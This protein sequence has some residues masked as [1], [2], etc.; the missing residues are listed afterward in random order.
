MHHSHTHTHPALPYQPR[1]G[2]LD[3]VAGRHHKHQYR[4]S[5][6]ETS[7][8]RQRETERERERER[9]ESQM[10]EGRGK[11]STLLSEIMQF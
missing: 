5:D 10:K 2:A 4:E 3:K 7:R 6:R 9:D 1:Q 11:N 8:E